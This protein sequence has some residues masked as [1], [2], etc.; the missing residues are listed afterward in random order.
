MAM[1]IAEC[2]NGGSS[3]PPATPS[4]IFGAS[5]LF[6]FL[7]S[8]NTNSGGLVTS[9]TDRSVNGYTVTATG[10]HRPTL[11]ANG[12]GNGQGSIF[13]PASTG[14]QGTIVAPAFPFTMLMI[15]RSLVDT[16]NTQYLHDFAFNNNITF[17]QASAFTLQQYNGT[18]GATKAIAGNADVLIESFFAGSASS[19]LG[20]NGGALTTAT[21]GTAA[22]TTALTLGSAGNGSFGS[23]WLGNVYEWICVSGAISSGQRA[24]IHAYAQALVGSP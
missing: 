2:S 15:V 21:N 10:T 19:G 4:S 5:L 20:S 11:N 8:N 24:A 7:W 17:Q 13:F 14:L 16:A 23:T 6:D 3:A 9:L 22:A 12:G 1:A 18:L